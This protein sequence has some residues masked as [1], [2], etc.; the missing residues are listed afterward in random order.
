M[1]SFDSI[2]NI[3]L[4]V[5]SI[6]LA[7]QAIWRH[8]KRKLPSKRVRRMFQLLDDADALL[9]S[10]GEEGL[11]YGEKAEGFRRNLAR[12]VLRR[13]PRQP[14]PQSTSEVHHCSQTSEIRGG[15]SLGSQHGEE[16]S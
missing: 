16:L 14:D 2:W 3:A 6:V 8:L 11:V 7:I 4:G 12:Y 5:L 1:A 10:C 13:S 15:S 9:L